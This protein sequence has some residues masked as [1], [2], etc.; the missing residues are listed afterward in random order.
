MRARTKTAVTTALNAE[1]V[2]TS[3]E[4]SKKIQAVSPKSKE[5]SQANAPVPPPPQRARSLDRVEYGIDK[6]IDLMKRLPD[7]DIHLLATVIKECLESA[8]IKIEKILEDAVAKEVRL[9]Q[10]IK[11][12]DNEIEN[13]ETMIHQRKETIFELIRDLEETRQVKNNLALANEAHE[14][15]SLAALQEQGTV[16]NALDVASEE[17]V[18]WLDQSSSQDLLESLFGVATVMAAHDDNTD[19][20]AEG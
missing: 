16:T 11:K 12:L 15:S 2:K 7:A 19:G 18:D 20:D 10:H 5:S 17:P 8:N 1:A 6:A 13:L 14:F 3:V 4:T 9:E